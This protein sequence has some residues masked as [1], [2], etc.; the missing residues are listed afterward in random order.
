[1]A[2]AEGGTAAPG[3]VGEAIDIDAKTDAK[4]GVAGETGVKGAHPS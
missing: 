3:T 2:N 1:M 4:E